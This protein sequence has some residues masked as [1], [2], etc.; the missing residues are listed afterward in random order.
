MDRITSYGGLE[1]TNR[2]AINFRPSADGKSTIGYNWIPTVSPG[3]PPTRDFNNHGPQIM[4]FPSQ[5]IEW[6]K[7]VKDKDGDH[8]MY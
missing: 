1:N 6:V 2:G 3:Q 7:V 4:G 8:I 5:V